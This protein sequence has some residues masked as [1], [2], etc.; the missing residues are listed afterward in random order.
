ML[1]RKSEATVFRRYFR[2]TRPFWKYVYVAML[3]MVFIT[4]V[5]IMLPYYIKII[6]DKIIPS[7]DLK[8]LFISCG[9]VILLYIIRVG[10]AIL[11]N[12]RMLNFG[13]HYI[14]DLRNRLMNHF[15]LL[16]FKYYDRVMTGDL[17][18][19]MLDD[20]MNVESM[21]TNALIYLLEDSFTLIAVSVIIMFINFKLAVLALLILP[22]YMFM[23][24]YFKNEI[25]QR[26]RNIKRNYADLSSEF[27]DSIAGVR[28]VRA[29][30][31]EEHKKERL[32]RYLTEDRKLRINTYTYNALFQA[33]TEFLTKFGVIL[34]VA[35]G[36]YFA[37]VD[38]SMTVGDIVAFYSYLSFLYM[39]IVRLSNA[40]TIIESGLTS[41]ERILE[42]LDTK[43]HPPEKVNP[44]I[45]EGRSKGKIVF[46]NVSFSYEKD[47]VP[48]LKNICIDAQPGKSIALVG[49]S[50]AG[51]STV[52]NMITRFYDPTEGAIL[53]DGHD[54]R[55]LQLKWIRKNISIVLQ[56]GF[57]FWGTI[58]E[59]I[60][61]GRVCASDTEVEKAAEMACAKEFIEKLPQGFDTPVGEKGVRLSGGQR[62][63][64]SIA[65][66]ILKNAPILFFD[67]ATSALDNESEYYIQEGM[68]RL[69]ENKTTFV[70]AHRLSTIENS[71][72]ILVMKNG[73]IVERGNHSELL[74]AKGLY[75]KLHNI[76]KKT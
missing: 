46:D 34:V 37:I 18:N 6:I 15:H 22:L 62:Q 21:T 50:G 29:Y 52:L 61:Y 12:N 20:V 40:T 23:R 24:R 69:S 53:L 4:S 42:V 16:S 59:N 35:G 7:G 1:S 3:M 72:T 32:N 27:Y 19:R 17:L 11:R 45:P 48:A 54:L 10:A 8:L 57:L 55:D 31:L 30:T 44:L 9:A 60:R 68:K 25:K 14:Y 5:G 2:S 73:R 41:M 63:R 58:R 70:I 71:D 51:K 39:P 67:E 56:D 33:L 28:E 36:G 74:A 43:P 64:V 13:Y 66:A 75:T 49:P 26:N 38:Q 65:R 47:Q 76:S